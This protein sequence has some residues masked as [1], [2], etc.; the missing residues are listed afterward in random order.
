VSGRIAFSA[1]GNL[2][3]VNAATGQNA[4]SPVSGMRQPDFLSGGSL[5]IANGE[6]AG[7]DSLWTIDANTGAFAHEQTSSPDD[8]HPFWSPDGTRFAYDSLHHGLTRRGTMLYTQGMT[9]RAR[10]EPEVTLGHSGQQIRGH[11]PVWMHNEWI[12]FTGCDYWPGGSGG[13]RCGICSM[14]SWGG[15][16][17]VLHTDSL[18]ARGTDNHG[19]SLLYMSQATGDWELYILPVEG[20]TGRNL[21]QSPGSLDGLGTFSPDGKWVAFVSNR[22]GW[23]VWAVRPDGTDLKKLFALP[24]PLTDDWTNEQISWGP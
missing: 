14:P 22:D 9:S 12:A 5:I 1:G 23:G 7:R 2:Y 19:A 6:G 10:K 15:E 13:S 21:S 18:T 16:P 24:A 20:G 17:R 11:S 4:V 3:I 8:F